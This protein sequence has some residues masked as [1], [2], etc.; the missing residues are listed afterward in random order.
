MAGLDTLRSEIKDLSRDEA[1]VY[2]VESNFQR[3][4]ILPSEK[5]FAY[6]MR[7]EAMKRQAGR[8]SKENE[9]PLG[10]DSLGKQTLEILGENTGDS[11]NQIH[12]YIRLTY[13]L[14]TRL[15]VDTS[16]YYSNEDFKDIVNFNTED[17]LN[18]L[19]Y[20]TGDISEMALSEIAKTVLSLDRANRTFENPQRSEYNNNTIQPE[21]RLEHDR[22]SLHQTGRLQSAQPDLT[23]TAEGRAGNVR[24]DEAQIP[25][26]AS[27]DPVLQPPDEMQ[28]DR[29]PVRDRTDG[30]EDGERSYPSD[31]TGSGRDGAAEGTGSAQ[32]GEK[33]EQHPTGGERNR[34]GQGD[35]HRIT[36]DGQTQRDD[37]PALSLSTTFGLADRIYDYLTDYIIN[38]YEEADGEPL[39]V[40]EDGSDPVVVA[41]IEHDLHDTEIM[42]AMLEYF[43]ET[44]DRR[45]N[46]EEINEQYDLIFDAVKERIDSLEPFDLDDRFVSGD[47]RF[48]VFDE[49]GERL[50]YP[51]FG[52]D[53]VVNEIFATTPY[54][55][56]SLEDIG[57]YLEGVSDTDRRIE[58]IRSI[59]NNDFTEII[60]ADDM[61]ELLN[62]KYNSLW[63]SVLHGIISSNSDIVAV[64]QEQI[65]NVG[66]QPY[67]SWYGFGSRVEWCCCFVSWCANECGYI[68]AGVI[69]KYS[70]VDDGVN[71]FK[72]KGQ[73]IDGSAEP[74][75]GMIIFFDW[76]DDGLDGSGDHMGI[77][78]KV[79]GGRVYTIEGNASDK[80]QELS[81][82][83]GY[84]EIL[85]YGFYESNS[86]SAGSGD[87][88]SQVWT[89]LKSYGYSDSVAAGII[90]NMMRECGGDTLDLDW[91][92]V[93]HYNGDEFYGLCQ[94]C[95]SYT[96]PGFKGS[97]VIAQCDYLKQTIQSA[98]ANYGGNYG[99][100]TY[101]EF[102]QS[103]TRTRCGDY[104]SEDNRRAN[105]A[106]RAY[107]HFH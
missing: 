83:V 78:E 28:A 2:M 77:V 104:A 7:N 64:A 25:E 54:L 37:E 56:A 52:V 21:R 95:L 27:Q 15:G 18:A 70:V 49:D 93:G 23:R 94:W 106:E 58:Y 79:E 98:F 9:S 96:P 46:D 16:L 22:D 42:R 14:M 66:G 68:D 80:C 11:R 102:L 59:F 82:S 91:D 50:K 75:P 86:S 5:A 63:S 84:H 51:F 47:T 81:Y 99:G 88:A 97:T 34:D 92:I 72:S 8:H 71:W 35:L 62:A 39:E 38:F 17:A 30:A 100:I 1:V 65:G 74:L 48:D 53:E 105:N 19:G 13:M 87:V 44:Y 32:L 20:A 24:S 45:D 61:H 89:R 40:V 90:G 29:E 60:L 12:R 76:E 101:I 4:T 57:A 10:I 36:P 33:D 73:W 26:R 107:N 103:D 3:S 6:K 41:R 43:S 69:P 55:S 31:G 85:G 67:W